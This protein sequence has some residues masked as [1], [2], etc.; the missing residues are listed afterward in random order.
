[1][2]TCN[3]I[4]PYH[5]LK[6]RNSSDI[7]CGPFSEIRLSGMPCSSQ[8][9]LMWLCW[10]C[11]FSV[12]VWNQCLFRVGD[13]M[14]LAWRSRLDHVDDAMIDTKPEDRCLC[15]KL[16]LSAPW[17]VKWI[18]SRYIIIMTNLVRINQEIWLTGMLSQVVIRQGISEEMEKGYPATFK[19]A[20]P[21]IMIAPAGHAWPMR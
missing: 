18:C 14:R 6:T 3:V 13:L 9:P 20:Y 5:E 19:K 21:A 15:T 16:A 1:M 17:C 12:F 8:I 10:S 2:V 7:D 4:E 11:G